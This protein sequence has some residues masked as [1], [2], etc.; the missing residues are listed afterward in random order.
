MFE[1]DKILN[2]G[3]MNLLQFDI[4]ERNEQNLCSIF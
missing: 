2:T 3:R 4:P 1:S